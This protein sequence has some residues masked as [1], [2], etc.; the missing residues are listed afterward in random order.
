M[1]RLFGINDIDY[2]SNGER[3]IKARKAEVYRDI[4]GE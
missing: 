3:I 1:I 2:R 4:D